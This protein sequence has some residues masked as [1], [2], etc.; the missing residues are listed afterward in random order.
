[1]SIYEPLERN[2]PRVFN[3]RPSAWGDIPTIIQDIINRTG[4][5]TNIALEFGVEYGYSTTA[6]S[7][8]F[9]K[10][11][12]V[13]IFTGDIHAGAV[14]DHYDS[15]KSNLAP[16]NNIE[17]IKANYQ[18]FIHENENRYDLVHIDIVHT[19]NETYE[20]GEWSVRHSDVVIFHDTESFPDIKKVC[21]DLALKYELN[22]YNYLPSH[23]LGILTKKSL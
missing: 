13:D 17:L 14:V 2:Q 12:G 18:E 1:M 4:I 21:E 7:N 10:V 5:K 6:L 16:W 11:I 9:D 8:Y 22:F 15:T 23:G 19:Y 20:C 3:E